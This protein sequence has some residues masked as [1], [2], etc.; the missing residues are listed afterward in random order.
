MELNKISSQIIK[1]A[2]SVRKESSLLPL[3]AQATLSETEVL[4]A[5]GLS[6]GSSS[7]ILCFFLLNCLHY[8]AVRTAQFTI[9]TPPASP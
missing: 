1:A 9:Q 7:I 6:T 4:G 5:E 8:S 2:L 3:L